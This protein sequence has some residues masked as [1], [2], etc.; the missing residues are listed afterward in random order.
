[1]VKFSATLITPPSEEATRL[2]VR[3]RT[4]LSWT[5]DHPTSDDETGVLVY[6]SGEILNGTNFRGLRD[7]LGSWMKAH[8]PEKACRALGVPVV[9]PGIVRGR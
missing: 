4:R 1:M 3:Q 6:A 8:S 5:T 9:A 7:T 2:G